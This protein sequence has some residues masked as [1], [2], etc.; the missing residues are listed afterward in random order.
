M[1]ERQEATHYVLGDEDLDRLESLLD[2]PELPEA[3]RLDEVQGYLCA[4][5]SGPQ[6]LP[7]D[8]W[9]ADVLGNEEA[10]ATDSGR[11]AAELLR[12]FA[13]SLEA[14]LAAGEPPILYL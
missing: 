5:L 13:R 6:P 12:A 4:V 9:L 14:S 10:L 2:E 3:M 7:E 8:V 11:D 1:S